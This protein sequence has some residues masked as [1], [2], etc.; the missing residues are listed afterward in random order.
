MPKRLRYYWMGEE[1]S[2][3]VVE[4]CTYNTPHSWTQVREYEGRHYRKCLDCDVHEWLDLEEDERPIRPPSL[5]NL[6]A[7]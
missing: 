7:Y 3:E 4:T 1:R 2:P 6:G 5:W